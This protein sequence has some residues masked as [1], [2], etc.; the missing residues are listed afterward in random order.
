MALASSS[1]GQP[2]GWTKQLSSTCGVPEE[3]STACCSAPQLAAGHCAVRWPCVD[4]DF[5]YCGLQA[6]SLVRSSRPQ[7]QL[8]ATSLSRPQP[9]LAM[10]SL[11]LHSPLRLATAKVPQVA[12]LQLLLR[13][14]EQ[15]LSRPLGLLSARQRLESRLPAAAP[16][17][18]DAPLH[19]MSIYSSS[20]SKRRPHH[21]S[22]Q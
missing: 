8:P 14:P 13:E 10:G 5:A 2:S 18:S 4:P 1:C 15:R 7:Q 19:A 20:Q 6:S 21:R 3:C 17:L 22:T 12:S 11:Q 9:H 16:S